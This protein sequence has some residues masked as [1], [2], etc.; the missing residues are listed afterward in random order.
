[1]EIVFD[2]REKY[3]I[4]LIATSQEPLFKNIKTENLELGD[5]IIKKDNKPILIFERKTF[6]DLAQS[7]KDGRYKEQ[8][9]RL[10]NNYNPNMIIY[11]L[12]GPLKGSNNKIFSGMKLGVIK[13]IIIKTLIRDN[14][15][16]ITSNDLDDTLYYIQTAY[17]KL[18]SGQISI[19]T[20]ELE[21]YNKLVK[22]EKKANVTC[23]K[24]L[25]ITLCQIPG[26]SSL[27]ATPIAKEYKTIKNLLNSYDKLETSGLREKMLKDMKCNEKRKVGPAVSKKIFEFLYND[28]ENV[29][30]Q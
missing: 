3:L 1:M 13:N 24:F 8:K 28:L 2:N 19:N 26:V 21:N 6:D 16:V 17:N 14:I 20:P 22:T 7:V 30:N 5:I 11:I 15:K 10:L 9:L 27:V 4:D 25:Y 18:E 29:N 23:D 12:E